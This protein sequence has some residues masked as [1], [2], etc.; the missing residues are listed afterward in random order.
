MKNIKTIR[1]ILVLII[2]SMIF[3]NTTCS[4]REII[5]KDITAFCFNV[6]KY[7]GTFDE[8]GKPNN[9]Y[10][11]DSFEN[12][13][14]YKLILDLTSKQQYQPEGIFYEVCPPGHIVNCS[15]SDLFVKKIYAT[16]EP[17]IIPNGNIEN[18]YVF[19]NNDYDSIHKA[20]D[21]LND[22]ILVSYLDKG[23][24]SIPI[25]LNYFLKDKPECK[26][27]LNFYFTAPPCEADTHI[28]TLQ[29]RETDGTSCE[30]I[31]N[32]VIVEP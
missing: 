30:M 31:F 5:K 10:A 9:A 7:D 21:I 20:G 12:V 26:F 23:I 24:H 1:I 15:F 13:K 27:S 22:I 32:P 19:S 28:F 16:I 14:F 4:D 11:L 6:L 3:Y 29:Y 8:Y 25:P 18:I 2:L 17:L